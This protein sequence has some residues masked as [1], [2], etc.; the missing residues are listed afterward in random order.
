MAETWHWDPTLFAGTAKYYRRGRLPYSAELADALRRFLD[1]DGR[2]RLIEVGSGPGIVGLSLAAIFE[3]VICIDPD[4]A[5]LDEGAVV[6]SAL[7]VTNVA[8]VCARAENL[9]AGLGTFR[10]A[11]FAQSF[12]WMERE[13]VAA[14]IFEMLQPGGAFVHVSQETV[15]P[16][17]GTDPRPSP[18]FP[19][20][21]DLVRRYLGEVR[22]AGRGL[23]P[24]GTPDG[25]AAVIEA[26]GFEKEKHVRLRGG[27]TLVRTVDD[28]IAGV[29]ARSDSA[30]HL[31]GADLPAF[32]AD[33]S[34]LLRQSSRDG[35]FVERQP[36]SVLRA[37]VKPPP[38][39]RRAAGAT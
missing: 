17:K 38:R 27:E 15:E 5:M 11:T 4:Q 34:N 20:I 6:A 9:P 2:G 26:A 19:E 13:R 1:L 32:E 39:A 33:L 14:A 37:W 23:L 22:R 18:P 29:F 31:F 36:D 24:H 30:P 10:V 3:E 12:H 35:S 7:G 25:E 21:G 8:W 28:V 16:T